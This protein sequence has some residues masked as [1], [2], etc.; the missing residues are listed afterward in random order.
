M[1]VKDILKKKGAKFNIFSIPTQPTPFDIEHKTREEFQRHR[2]VH[3]LRNVETF[4]LDL[5]ASEQT[6]VINKDSLLK[7]V[8]AMIKEILAYKS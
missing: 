1:G 5:Q 8:R 4:L 2:V 6:G 7:E 3:T